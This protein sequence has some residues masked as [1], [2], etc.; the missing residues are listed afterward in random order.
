MCKYF[1]GIITVSELIDFLVFGFLGGPFRIASCAFA[2]HSKVI[3][4]S[5]RRTCLTICRALS[6]SPL[7][8]MTTKLAFIQLVIFIR[9]FTFSLCAFDFHRYPWVTKST[10]L[11]CCCCWFGAISLSCGDVASAARQMSKHFLTQ[12]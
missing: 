2:F 6:S 3:R 7:V 4:F 12:A 5:T 11:E 8:F 1:A 9:P 10:S